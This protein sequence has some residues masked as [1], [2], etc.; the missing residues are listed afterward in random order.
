MPSGLLC[1]SGIPSSLLPPVQPKIYAVSV[2]RDMG[3]KGRDAVVGC[4]TNFNVCYLAV[5]N[6]LSWVSPSVL[7]SCKAKSSA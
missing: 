7:A 3:L 2:D 1:I 5:E 4:W 6:V